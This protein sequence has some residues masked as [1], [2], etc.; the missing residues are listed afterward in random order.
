VRHHKFSKLDLADIL[1]EAGN[2][3]AN[4]DITIETVFDV[5]NAVAEA[6]RGRFNSLWRLADKH[7]RAIGI[8]RNGYVWTDPRASKGTPP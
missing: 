6:L 8:C 5:V 1:E 3:Y 7:A 2:S 4:D